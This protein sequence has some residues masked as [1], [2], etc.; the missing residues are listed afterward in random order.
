M[1]RHESG[2]EAILTERGILKF[3]LGTHSFLS[4]SST[5]LRSTPSPFAM[6]EHKFL[7]DAPTVGSHVL[8]HCGDLHLEHILRLHPCQGI[9][10]FPDMEIHLYQWQHLV[11][12]VGS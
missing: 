5:A 1:N 11:R 6:N 10:K 3:C 4:R 2:T 12:I 8:S 7:T 9:G